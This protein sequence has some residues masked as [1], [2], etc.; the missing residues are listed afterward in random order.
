[1][2]SHEGNRGWYGVRAFVA[3]R[4][5]GVLAVSRETD[6]I[7]EILLLFRKKAGNSSGLGEFVCQEVW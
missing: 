7:N 1:M 4:S 6:S 3:R 5:S 2:R